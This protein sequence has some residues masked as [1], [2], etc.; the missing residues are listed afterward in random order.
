MRSV[1][2]R[3]IIDQMSRPAALRTH[4]TRTASHGDL[5]DRLVVSYHGVRSAEHAIGAIRW[6]ANGSKCQAGGGRECGGRWNGRCVAGSFSLRRSAPGGMPRRTRSSQSAR[7]RRFRASR[8]R[9]GRSTTP[10]SW[11]ACRRSAASGRHRARATSSIR[12]EAAHAGIAL[13]RRR[14]AL[15]RPATRRPGRCRRAGGHPQRGRAAAEAGRSRSRRAETGASR[16]A[17][18]GRAGRHVS[19]HGHRAGV[20][21]AGQ[22]VRPR[23]T[24]AAV[25]GLGPGPRL[26]PRCVRARA[27]PRGGAPGGAVAGTAAGD[28]AAARRPRQVFPGPRLER[29]RRSPITASRW[30]WGPTPRGSATRPFWRGRPAWGSIATITRSCSIPTHM[31]PRIDSASV[32][33]GA[34]GFGRLEGVRAPRHGAVRCRRP[35]ASRFAPARSPC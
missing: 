6:R 11:R 7:P 24:R 20:S 32:C 30:R 33:R 5:T 22:P 21:R 26:S 19:V 18:Q 28:L 13:E 3:D 16:I 10:P 1:V 29:R 9:S 35:R 12:D 14:R 34:A 15:P 31:T 8:S 27:Q 23:A 2:G 17:S 4:D 25:R